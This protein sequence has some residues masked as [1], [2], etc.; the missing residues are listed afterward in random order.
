V[1]KFRYLY[2][3]M[4][5]CGTDWVYDSMYAIIKYCRNSYL[6]NNYVDIATSE[7]DMDSEFIIRQ[8]VLDTPLIRSLLLREYE[9]I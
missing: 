8:D 4:D 3:G 2:V 7:D 9:N 1:R 6:G 5:V